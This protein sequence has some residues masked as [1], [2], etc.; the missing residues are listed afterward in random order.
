MAVK[1]TVYGR[2]DMRDLAKA[3]DELDRLERKAFISSNKFAGAMSH[4]AS[5]TKRIGSSLSSTG[6]AMTKNLTLPL[7]AVGAGLVKATQ[8]AAQDA[9]Q[10]VVLANA[11]KRNAGATDAVVAS[12]EAWISKQGELLGVADDQLRPALSSLVGATKDVQKAQILATTAMDISAATGVDVET[13]AKAL[14]KAYMGNTGQLSKMVVGIDKAAL[15]SK[16]FGAIYQSVNKIVGGQAAKSADTAAGA[17]AR[18]KVAFNEATEQLG[19]AFMPIMKDLANFIQQNVV[20]IIQSLANWFGSL[21]NEQKNLVV[22]LGL[23]LAVMGPLV[24]VTGRVISGIGSMANAMI[25]VAQ[26]T[27]PLIGG[28]Q[29]FITGLTHAG[30][31]ASAFATPMMKLGGAIR[32][33]AI[34]TWDFT[35][36]QLASMWQSVKNAA[37]YVAETA[38]LVAHKIALYATE[39]ATKAWTAAQWLLN[40]AL[41][42][43]PIGIVI[44]L[45]GALIAV[46]VL[47][48]THT[49]ELSDTFS[50]TWDTITKWVV[51]SIQTINAW[52]QGFITTMENVAKDA[53][54]G[55]INGFADFGNKLMNAV[56]EPITNAVDWVK[57][58]LGI[59]SPSTVTHEI[60][61]NFGQGFANGITDTTGSAVNAASE[62]AN[63]TTE[64]LREGMFNVNRQTAVQALTDKGLLG[65]AQS[66][67]IDPKLLTDAVLGD[68]T[69]WDKAYANATNKITQFKKMYGSSI[70]PWVTTFL[71]D[72]EGVR[73][74]LKQQGINNDLMATA[75]GDTT[76]TGKKIITASELLAEKIKK[77]AELA[78]DA[79]K[80]WSM[81]QVVKPIQL[82]METIIEAIQ[83]QITATANFLNNMAS[84]KGRLNSSAYNALLSMGAAQ[85]GQFAQALQGASAEQLAQ[86]N[87]SYGEQLR[88]TSILGQVQSGAQQAAPVVISEGAIQVSIAGNADSGVVTDAMTEAI[89]ALVREMRSR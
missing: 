27:Q 18:T 12:T 40:I 87:T 50:S 49:Q 88:L 14:G 80:S 19:Y 8:A 76:N 9:Q 3:R 89:N 37:T 39:I 20:P 2:A 82:S 71:Y 53:V 16:D 52:L 47:I 75:L 65:S 74:D 4:I 7:V 42:A 13:A 72:M 34:A 30:A 25:S 84:L 58:K 63:R 78:K 67:G 61:S 54:A 29:N 17:M 70:A 73:N 1:I 79:M 38:G 60:G 11:L 6:D 85:G 26:A 81:D 57:D 69:S 32:T 21:T 62:M 59:H 68:D 35:K 15:K 66:L 64:A 10:Q 36:A 31:G 33:A 46:I 5:S 77:G 83:S 43:N 45:V 23:V 44:L 22:G 28:I 86:Y 41:D 24:S 55:F 48:A 51:G 56:A